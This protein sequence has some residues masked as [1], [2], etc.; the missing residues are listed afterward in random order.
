MFAQ[1]T[2]RGV[3]RDSAQHR[4]L[5]FV[6]IALQGFPQATAMSDIDGHFSIVLPEGL[7]A[8]LNFSY[9][10]YRPEQVML[11]ADAI[12]KLNIVMKPTSKQL[13]VFE[14]K[15]GENP[16]HRIIRNTWKRRL[17]HDPEQL[18]SY[19]CYTY[20]KLVLSG[21]PDT[22]YEAK[23]EEDA[24]KVKSYDSLF[25][26]QHLFLIE[27]SNERLFRAGKVKENVIG[28]KVSGLK[29]ASV[30]MLALQFQPFSFYAP[31]VEING[32]QLLNPISKN[33]EAVYAFSLE[34]TLFN[35]VDSIYVI[36]FAPSKNSR[37]QGMKG[38]IYIS[39]PDYA[40]HNVIAEPAEGD[41]TIKLR[42]QQQ[43]KRLP[44][45][46]WFPEQLHTDMIF[47]NVN[48]T[49]Y[50][51]Y[52]ESRTYISKPE[53]NPILSPELFDEVELDV[54]RNSSDRS[55]TY[56]DTARIEELNEREQHTYY[57]LDSI[58]K[59]EN[60]APK[61]KTIEALVR[62]YI[63]INWFDLEIN[64]L[65]RFNNH[66]GLRLGLGGITNDKVSRHFG[67]GGYVAYGLKDKVVKYGG[68]GRLYLHPRHELELRIS[69]SNDVWESGTQTF[70]NDRR[71]IQMELVRQVLVRKMDAEERGT[72]TLGW[73]WLKYLKTDVFVKQSHST[74]NYY[75]SFGDVPLGSRF[76]WLEQGVSLTYSYK[77]KFYRNGKLKISLGGKSPTFRV[78]FTQGNDLNAGGISQFQRV[79]VR[80]DYTYAWRRIGKTMLQLSGGL[81]EGQVPYAR[82]YNGKGNLSGNADLRA[83]SMFCFETMELN[84]F[85][86]D[87]FATLFLQHNMGSFFRIRKFKPN[88]VLV[89]N[90]MIGSLKKT[91]AANQ[92][93]ILFKTPN[94]GYFECGLLLNNIIT[95]STDGYG[96]G[97]FYRYGTYSD[98]D[99]KKN[100][101][102]KISISLAL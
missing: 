10:G 74:P 2:L 1:I 45:G 27:S 12:E 44:S 13:R 68:E 39:V 3:V 15:A 82:L 33:S 62:G 50:M 16:A 102:L 79:D 41:N 89:Q 56:W 4:P 32:K 78:L 21:R 85:L 76:S 81:V 96:L 91:T 47:Q 42:I 14:V 37:I 77:E 61:L 28:S 29:D 30:F 57:L 97:A 69:Y 99:W 64:R 54:Q 95:L 49:G 72:I 46:N 87:R 84:E 43:Y 100:I 17:Q 66:E 83:A 22:A 9:I 6:S 24:R 23:T 18:S 93:G 86:T 51:M 35:A 71:P 25:N 53:I 48:L 8:Q 7:P 52:G 34:D 92:K 73:R 98:K 101:T 19:R 36:R 59:A 11:A 5:A 88:F 40:I 67:L 70:I 58:S 38:V 31:L 20:N 63:P 55:E 94:Q 65:I 80:V 26:K 60:L 90:S 75:Y